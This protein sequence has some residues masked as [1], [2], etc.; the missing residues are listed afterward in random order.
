MKKTLYSIILLIVSIL[1]FAAY[2][3]SDGR[4]VNYPMPPDSMMAL[5]PRCDF[6]IARYWQRC[7]FDYAMLHP[8]KFNEAFGAWVTIMP[9]A[10]ADTVHAAIDNLLGRFEKNAAETLALATMA[11]NWLYSD[12]AQFRSYELYMPFAKAAVSNKKIKKDDKAIFVEDYKRLSSS[13][14]GQTVPSMPTVLPDG[15]QSDFDQIKGSSILL[16]FNEPDNIDCSLARIRLS[17]DSNVRELVDRGELTVVSINPATP[18]DKWRQAVAALPEKWYKVAI[19]EADSYFDLRVKPQFLYLDSH[20]K[21]LAT[22]L[23]LD[24][25]LGAFETANKARKAELSS[26]NNE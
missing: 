17:S 10:S 1:P 2:A 16:F 8:D 19:P 21:V 6:I 12:T 15:T 14:V 4:L 11:R 24:Y 22:N 20:H 25:L 26:E 18:D 13:S 9:H 23:S 5:Q 3:Q 7:K